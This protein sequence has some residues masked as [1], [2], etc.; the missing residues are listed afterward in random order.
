M[1]RWLTRLRLK[2]DVP[3]AALARVLLP[4]NPS[5]RSRT[6]HHLLWTL[7]ADREDRTRDFLWREERPGRGASGR[8]GFLVL[9]AREP[10]D[11]H[12][13]FDMDEPKPWQPA[14]APGD[15]LAFSLR[16]NPVVTRKDAAGKGRRCDVVMDRL[17]AVPKGERAL[18]RGAAVREAGRDW[19]ERQGRKHGFAIERGEGGHGEDGHGEGRPILRVDGYE[20]LRIHREGKPASPRFSVIELD[21]VLRVT[22]PEALLAAV[23]AGFG[24]AK[25]WGCG[26]ML[27]RRA[28]G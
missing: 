26:L 2:R 11:H 19:L 12:A 6:A 24:K 21:G 9:S 25:A 7:F 3:A 10:V 13:L 1:T 8:G 20:Q 17:H 18:A 22:E 5:E 28:R 15:R 14:L 16:A 23:T 27:L 4:D